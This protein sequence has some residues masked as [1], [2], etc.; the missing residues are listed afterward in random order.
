MDEPVDI[1]EDRGVVTITLNSPS[2]RNAL[3]AAL[4]T[5]MHRGIDIA[6]DRG[7][8]IVLRANGNAFCAGADLKE[9]TAGSSS[10]SPPPDV[11]ERLVNLTVPVLAVVEGAA[12]AGGVGLVAAADVAIGTEDAN[13]AVSEVHR[14]LLPA[15]IS[16]VC[17]QRLNFRMMQQYFLTGE[18]FDAPVASA[19]GLLS[20]FVDSERLEERIETLSNLFRRGA[21]QALANTKILLRDVTTGDVS[22]EFEEMKVRSRRA[23]ESGDGQ[24]GMR[25]FLEKREPSWVSAEA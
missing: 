10:D 19:M 4:V 3:S 24:E 5:E 7:R 18:Q 9:R 1:T 2:N 11:F 13:F 14:G 25:A 17:S 22:E 12:R 8:L 15:V 21:P 23:F 6:E 20:E 16:V